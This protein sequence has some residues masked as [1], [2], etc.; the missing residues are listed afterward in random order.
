MPEEHD[1]YELCQRIQRYRLKNG[2]AIRVA[3]LGVS[4]EFASK[5][6]ANG[7]IELLPSYE[8]GPAI[9]VALTEKGLAMAERRRR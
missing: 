5:L 1:P 4:E 8:G 6:V 9:Y 7:V 3:E 2:Y